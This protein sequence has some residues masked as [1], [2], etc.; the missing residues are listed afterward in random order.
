M[1]ISID[2]KEINLKPNR[3]KE[4]SIIKIHN[5]WGD[6]SLNIVED[7]VDDDKIDS[8]IESLILARDMSKHI[9]GEMQ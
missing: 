3:F 9:R 5:V 4:D 1:S 6:I 2:Q 7:K 8:L